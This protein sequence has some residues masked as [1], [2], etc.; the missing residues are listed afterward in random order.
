MTWVHLS[1]LWTWAETKLQI[2]HVLRKQIKAP[3]YKKR[4]PN[5]FTVADLR[6]LLAHVERT[7]DGAKRDTALRDA[8]IVLTL[9]D[10]GLRASEL[11]ALTIA[12]YDPTNA[13][14]HIVS[15][16]SKGGGKE[17]FV[18][19]GKRTQKTLWRY[20]AK[21]QTTPR[22]PLFTTRSDGPLTRT[23]LRHLLVRLGKR[24]GIE[25]VHPHRFHHTF[26][27]AFLRNGG[28]VALLKELLGHE[29]IEMSLH[30]ADIA[31]QDIDASIQHSPVDNWRL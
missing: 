10:T 18:V 22:Q 8:A 21:R 4:K 17:R 1:S 25:H 28:S 14:L 13:R 6:V 7:T 5:P 9:L 15:G 2:P 16:K 23:D 24:A 30:Y 29:T 3:A 11:C 19:V 31:Q 20:L 26:A 27:I 12:D